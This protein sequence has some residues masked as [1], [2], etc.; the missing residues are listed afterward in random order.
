MGWG[1]P[2]RSPGFLRGEFAGAVV[3]LVLLRS[4][5]GLYFWYFFAL[6]AT[7]R[8]IPVRTRGF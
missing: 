8:F 5:R 2:C 4:V 3:G 7:V 6:L 1:L